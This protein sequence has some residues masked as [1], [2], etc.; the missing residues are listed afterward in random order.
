MG[1]LSVQ[2]SLMIAKQTSGSHMLLVDLYRRMCSMYLRLVP[3]HK[4]PLF[5]LQTSSHAPTTR[6]SRSSPQSTLTVK[7]DVGIWESPARHMKVGQ[8]G[9]GRVSNSPAY[10]SLDG[11]CTLV[12]PNGYCLRIFQ[13]ETGCGLI[14]LI[15]L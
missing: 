11:S 4:S 8:D 1:Y 13:A 6:R 15:E 2:V 9:L 5:K 12:F 14:G 3:R 7:N 10:R